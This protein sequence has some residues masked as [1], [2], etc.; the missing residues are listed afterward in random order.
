VIT[1]R[2]TDDGLLIFTNTKT[3]NFARVWEGDLDEIADICKTWQDSKTSACAHLSKYDYSY[4]NLQKAL[5]ELIDLKE[6]ADAEEA[7]TDIQI[8]GD[9]Y[10]DLTTA[11]DDLTGIVNKIN[12]I[13]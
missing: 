8:D 3:K 10:L 9:D 5:R 7:L 1:R 12:R 13:A 2:S 4:K 6:A 11:I